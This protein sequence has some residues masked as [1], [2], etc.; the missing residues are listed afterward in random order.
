LEVLDEPDAKASLIWIIG[1]YA[2]RIDNAD[3][4]MGYFLDNFTEENSQVQLQLLTATVKLFLKKPNENQ[5]LV[6]TVLQTASTECDN[7]DIRDRSYIYWRLLS[8]DP[9]AAKSVVLSEKPPIAGE[10]QEL[11][12]SLLDT[13]VADIGSI[14]SVYHKP[15]ETFIAGKK[16][17]PDHVTKTAHRRDDDEDED[18]NAPP[19]KIREAMKNNDVG[20]LLDLDWSEPSVQEPFSN[21]SPAARKNALDDLLSLNT[22]TSPVMTVSPAMNS[23]PAQSSSANDLMDL[24]GTSPVKTTTNIN[25]TPK[26]DPF[27]D[28]F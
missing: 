13:L 25:S 23:S 15:A 5:G 17:S 19:E 26:N 14:A 28:L 4:L 2:E 27:A 12:P 18:I 20:D 10:S 11:S 22:V 16:Y 24:F 7:A 1:E 21:D 6:Q 9:N 3:D 8:T